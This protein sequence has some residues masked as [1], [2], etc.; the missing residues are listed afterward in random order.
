M[1]QVIKKNNKRQAKPF[2]EAYRT[3]VSRIMINSI[4]FS[5]S[6]STKLKKMIIID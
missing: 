6:V 4:G 3:G 5:L 1:Q 2:L